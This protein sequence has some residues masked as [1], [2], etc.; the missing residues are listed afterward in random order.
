M[1]FI[2]LCCLEML[3][4][5]RLILKN[6]IFYSFSFLKNNHCIL[7]GFY[8]FWFHGPFYSQKIPVIMVGW[9]KIDPFNLD[10]AAAAGF[11]G[12][13]QGSNWD[14]NTVPKKPVRKN[15]KKSKSWLGLLQTRIIT[16]V[17]TRTFAG[18]GN[19]IPTTKKSYGPKN[20]VR[21]KRRYHPQTH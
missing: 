9:N 21:C 20:G 1:I 2:M 11:L 14:K 7:L 6:F 15:A 8:S 10:V 13:I 16:N 5:N 17:I 18:T 3:F 12:P 4:L 19:S